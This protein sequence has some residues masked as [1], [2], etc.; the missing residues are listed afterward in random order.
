M[1]RSRTTG[2]AG[3]TVSTIE[4]LLLA[5]GAEW[6]RARARAASGPPVLIATNVTGFQHA[7]LLEAVLAIALTLRGASVEFL[8]CDAAMPACLRAEQQ[9]MPAAESF[10]AR[11]LIG[12]TCPGC[13]ALGRALL[14][15]LEL[16]THAF[17]DL[18]SD[19][20]RA[21]CRRLAE[22]V[23]ANEIRRFRYRQ[24]SVG[25][26]AEAGALRYFARGDL[27]GIDGGEVVLRRYFEGALIAATAASNLLTRRRYASACFHHGIYVPQGPMGEACRAAGVPVVNWNPSYRRNTFIFS[28]G[29][30][31]HHT[32]MQ[33][34]LSA[35][36]ELEWTDAMDR[37]IMSYLDSRRHGGRDWIWFHEKPDEDFARY[38]REIG[39]DPSKPVIGLLTNVVWDAQLHYPANAFGNMLE[40]VVA[41]I[42]Y[43]S[44]RPGLQLL[45]RVHPAEIRGTVPSR[46]PVTEEIRRAFPTLPANVFVVPPEAQVSTYAAMEA[47]DAALVYGTKTGVELASYGIPV[48]VGGEAW[49]RN[50]GLTWDASSDEEYF[51]LLDEL[52]FGQRMPS[53]TVREARRYAYH[54]FFRRMIPLPFLVPKTG[55][56]YDLSL[57]SLEEL[58]PGV[59]PGLDVVCDGILDG[60][61]FIYESERQ[62]I[63]DA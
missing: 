29:D 12:R 26:H 61:P 4:D 5:H 62:G 60:T 58:M 49:I 52:P 30:T 59:H 40:W 42:A 25:E 8:V 53:A 57:S 44:R 55:K 50:K 1:R 41:T 18:L 14:G 19:A 38:A 37:E 63:H 16:T 51:R 21:D 3:T 33:E 43:F 6:S 24:M 13:M 22:T 35:W 45:I 2:E 56:I 17:S 39:L 15:P 9:N 31:Y 27:C 23:P 34:P 10:R 54:F 7:T 28:H 20:E 48:I 32:L 11:E 47:C 36:K 46:Q